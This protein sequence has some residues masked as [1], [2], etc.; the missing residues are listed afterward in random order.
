MARRQIFALGLAPFSGNAGMGY[1]LKKASDQRCIPWDKVDH[2]A[3]KIQFA[4]IEW[5]SSNTTISISTRQF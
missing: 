1:G 5:S 2:Q 4:Q 3:R